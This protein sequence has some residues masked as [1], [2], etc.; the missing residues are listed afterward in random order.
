MMVRDKVER[1]MRRQVL[2]D[3][4]ELF[5]IEDSGTDSFIDYNLLN[6]RQKIERDDKNGWDHNQQNS[7]AHGREIPVYSSSVIRFKDFDFFFNHWVR[8]LNF[9]LIAAFTIYLDVSCL[10]L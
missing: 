8:F 1:G 9:V 3:S 7:P 6:N 10:R 2:P 4:G 5:F